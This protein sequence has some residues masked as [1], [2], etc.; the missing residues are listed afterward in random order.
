MSLFQVDRVQIGNWKPRNR[1]PLAKLKK[2]GDR[3]IIPKALVPKGY[4]NG[5]G[6]RRGMILSVFTLKDGSKE[7][8]LRGWREPK[9]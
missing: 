6:R 5:I 9:P 4:I 3:F 2:I 7:V 1:Y 8:I